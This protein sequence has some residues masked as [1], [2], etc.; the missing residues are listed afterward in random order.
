MVVVF[1]TPTSDGM[2][3][4]QLRWAEVSSETV[5]RMVFAVRRRSVS[6]TATRLCHRPPLAML[7]KRHWQSRRQWGPGT[8][9]SS[10]SVEGSH[11]L[12]S[13]TREEAS[14]DVLWANPRRSC[15]RVPWR[16]GK[17]GF[18]D[19]AERKGCGEGEAKIFLLATFS[20]RGCG[21][22]SRISLR[23]TR[24]RDLGVRRARRNMPWK[25][26]PLSPGLFGGLFEPQ[27]ALSLEDRLLFCLPAL[28]RRKTSFGRQ[29]RSVQAQ[30]SVFDVTPVKT[31]RWQ[32]VRDV[33]PCLVRR[34]LIE[35]T[36]QGSSTDVTHVMDE[37]WH[38]K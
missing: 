33:R 1:L 34:S 14:L 3:E 6:P 38:Q 26:D 22:R 10:K 25:V 9:P 21:S 19:Q 36:A 7:S 29:K 11:E 35:A 4:P 31:A 28:S 15:C 2:D 13:V 12:V 27:F 37:M 18:L 5:T 16:K 17:E 32:R 8:L 24:R 30:V 23:L 20:T